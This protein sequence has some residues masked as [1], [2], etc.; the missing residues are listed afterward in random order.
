MKF[1]ITEILKQIAPARRSNFS[2]GY[3][4]TLPRP[5]ER[6]ITAM[7]QR[8]PTR[9]TSENGKVVALNNSRESKEA[10][11]PYFKASIEDAQWI[12]SQSAP[13]Q[14]LWIECQIA[15]HFGAN[16]WR[17]VKTTLEASTFRKAKTV[18]QKRGLFDF[19]AVPGISGKGRMTV[20][21]W[22]VHNKHG[23]YNKQYWEVTLLPTE[24]PCDTQ[25]NVALQGATLLP[26]ERR[27]SVQSEVEPETLTRERFENSQLRVNHVSTTH[28]LPTKV[29]G[30]V[31]SIPSKETEESPLGGI[32]PTM[33]DGMPE[34]E[35]GNDS[36]RSTDEVPPPPPRGSEFMADSANL[37]VQH[38]LAS[39][40]DQ[41]QAADEELRDLGGGNSSA[42]APPL[43]ANF[44]IQVGDTVTLDW[45]DSPFHG[46]T[47]KVHGVDVEASEADIGFDGL[48]FDATFPI[49]RLFRAD[50]PTSPDQLP[51]GQLND[52]ASLTVSDN[53][54]LVEEICAFALAH[55]CRIEDAEKEETQS[56]NSNQLEKVL[57]VFQ[58]QIAN[59]S[60]GRGA[61][62]TQRFQFA[63][64]LARFSS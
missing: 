30:G 6:T 17:E 41:A 24:Q 28:Q 5:H 51:V 27:C 54:N 25:S 38:S 20:A 3:L 42:A 43:P 11:R 62:K 13:V 56:F 36:L 47:G 8:P 15:E 57:S 18:L 44:P 12:T 34:E 55:D 16:D 4:Q 7:V 61:T 2:Q 39:L 63:L 40:E 26:T 32:P 14:Q 22:L 19:K 60:C 48:D 46:R 21:G 29:V 35:V 9:H 45:S 10:V 64:R 23:Y 50:P 59:W 53:S 58:R 37:E 52:A 49:G 1:K 33:R 31:V